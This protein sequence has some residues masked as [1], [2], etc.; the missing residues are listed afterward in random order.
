MQKPKNGAQDQNSG[1][2]DALEEHLFINS[3][4][5]FV[6]NVVEMLMESE[7][8]QGEDIKPQAIGVGINYNLKV[9]GD[10][11]M[12]YG[13][14]IRSREGVFCGR[15]ADTLSMGGM[16]G[17]TRNPTRFNPCFTATSQEILTNLH[18]SAAN[19]AAN[20]LGI[21][22]DRNINQYIV[23]T[24]ITDDGTTVSDFGTSAKSERRF[25]DKHDMFIGVIQDVEGKKDSD[26]PGESTRRVDEARKKAFASLSEY[27]RW[28]CGKQDI[29]EDQ[30]EQFVPRYNNGK[31]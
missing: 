18:D 13:N 19:K 27:F 10:S 4:D 17:T 2:N 24:G 31:V 9:N 29:S 26:G 1:G 16:G 28:F 25:E 12:K 7:D 5:R 3:A 15:D 14:I 20:K 22:V 21:K 11:G 8:G 30:L 6:G 23:N